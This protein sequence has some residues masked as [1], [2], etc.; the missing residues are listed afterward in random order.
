MTLVIREMPDD[1]ARLFIGLACLV[2]ANN[3]LRA[4]YVAPEAARTSI[5]KAL[6]MKIEETAR[7]A[8]IRYLYADSSLTAEQF[9]RSQGYE[10]IEYGQH[11]LRGRWP[12]ADGLCKD[13]EG[14]VTTHVG[15]VS[16]SDLGNAHG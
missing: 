7:N 15:F 10:V 11:L 5:G 13:Q 1:D 2:I 12:S 4:C 16:G 3:E 8:G 6:L 14:A 9:Y